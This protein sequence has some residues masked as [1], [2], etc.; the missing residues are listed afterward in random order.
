M[1]Q[2]SPENAV[3]SKE[4]EMC[5]CW[6]RCAQSK[7]GWRGEKLQ[8]HADCGQKSWNHRGVDSKYC[9]GT[10]FVKARS[11]Y[12][13]NMVRQNQPKCV[14]LIIYSSETSNRCW[15]DLRNDIKDV[16]EGEV[17]PEAVRGG[18][19]PGTV[20]KLL[21]CKSRFF[22]F[23]GIS[24]PVTYSLMQQVEQGV[25][26]KSRAPSWEEIQTVQSSESQF[27]MILI[28]GRNDLKPIAW[29]S[30]PGRVT[31]KG[32]I[33]HTNSEQSITSCTA[34]QGFGEIGM[35]DSP[36]AAGV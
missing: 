32:E 3:S 15:S 11:K 33:K 23:P 22:P 21:S 16:M 19:Q 8:P 5:Q 18:C 26:C 34:L 1:A 27:Q 36:E 7:Q 31:E 28:S 2:F 35:G 30:L 10:Q 13:E 12:R 29:A 4:N 25:Q 24:S 20:L 14:C 17:I 9:K 6:L